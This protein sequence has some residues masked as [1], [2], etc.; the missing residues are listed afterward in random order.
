ML[1]N[2][3]PKSSWRVVDGVTG[4]YRLPVGKPS[5]GDAPSIKKNSYAKTFSK[6]SYRTTLRLFSFRAFLWAGGG[7]ERWHRQGRER[8]RERLYGKNEIPRL[9][10][11]FCTK[12]PP[13]GKTRLFPA[14]LK[15]GSQHAICWAQARLQPQRHTLKISTPMYVEGDPRQ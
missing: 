4:L 5:S 3:L 8:Y 10:K 13:P 7:R 1:L 2:E 9:C 11:M 15:S 6:A 14:F 12:A